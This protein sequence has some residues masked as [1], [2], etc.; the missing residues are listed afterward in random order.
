MTATVNPRKNV[1]TL[2]TMVG[3]TRW[4]SSRLEKSEYNES[5]END[6]SASSEELGVSA[7]CSLRH[8]MNWFVN[9]LN[10]KQTKSLHPWRRQPGE[11][12]RSTT[13]EKAKNFTQLDSRATHRQQELDQRVP[14]TF[15]A[16]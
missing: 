16:P 13:Q 12:L 14:K 7:Q 10:S 4:K 3:K 1:T 8:K 9:Q 6:A 5:Q 15:V 2:S 11:T